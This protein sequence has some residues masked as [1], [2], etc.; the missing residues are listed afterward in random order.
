MPTGVKKSQ[1]HEK[2]LNLKTFRTIK[3]QT[4][5]P[6]KTHFTSRVFLGHLDPGEVLFAVSNCSL[7]SGLAVNICGN[8]PILQALQMPS[9]E[10]LVS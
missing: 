8:S 4:D 6:P 3:E 7:R 10:A 2:S 5:P 1:K 9:W